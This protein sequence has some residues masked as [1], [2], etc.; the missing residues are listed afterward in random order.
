MAWGKG[1]H[2]ERPKDT[3]V[4][5]T[6]WRASW[7]NQ[8]KEFKTYKKIQSLLK[9]LTWK[10]SQFPHSKAKT[11][12]LIAAWQQQTLPATE[13][14]LHWYPTWHIAVSTL[15]QLSHESFAVLKLLK[16]HAYYV[17]SL[18]FLVYYPW[19]HARTPVC[20]TWK[21]LPKNP[22]WVENPKSKIRNPKSKIQD[23]SSGDF[24]WFFV[25][26]KKLVI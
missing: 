19:T 9:I 5:I 20:V 15:L 3:D 13:C 2:S 11:N 12:R 22:S 23:P 17:L 21:C 6:T 24:F 25:V 4:V 14:H 10:V 18:V 26:P 7:R 1:P 8:S 16:N